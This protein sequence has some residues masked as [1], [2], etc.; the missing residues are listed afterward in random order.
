MTRLGSHE[1][2]R[3]SWGTEFDVGQSESQDN[4]WLAGRRAR[5]QTQAG[6]PGTPPEVTGRR[7]AL[8]SPADDHADRAARAVDLRGTWALAERDLAPERH[9]PF[10]TMPPI[11]R[12]GRTQDDVAAA[13]WW[14]LGLHGGAGVSTL[15]EAIPGGADAHGLWPSPAVHPGPGSVV[16]VARTHL[17]GLTRA[18][19]AIQQWYEGNV[20]NGLRLAGL[21]VVAD[22]PGR[23]LR[24]QADAL[25]L[26]AGIVRHVWRI[27]WIE[28]LRCAS[29]LGD[30]VTP[31]PIA[32]LAVDLNRRHS[33]AARRPGQGPTEDTLAWAQLP[34][35]AGQ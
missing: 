28:E 6:A 3:G 10:W 24:P 20:P 22:A 26:L 9:L 7:P 18:R 19:D 16:L 23:L 13:G 21:V 25:R 31:P 29:D 11:G 17:R 35:G 34:H 5:T 12:D 1:A 8:R 4:P 30:L 2:P 27:P 15:A 32:D 33:P 14:W